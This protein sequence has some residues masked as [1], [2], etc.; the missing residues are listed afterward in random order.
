MSD[1]LVEIESGKSK[2][3]KTANKVCTDNI[4][5][6][7]V[8]GEKPLEYARMAPNFKG[9]ILPEGSEL[10]LDM[11]FYSGIYTVGEV[12]FSE[13]FYDATNLKK[14]ILKGNN[15]GLPLDAYCMFYR[16]Q[17]LEVVD[18][19]DFKFTPS[20]ADYL[21]QRSS[22]LVSING[23]IDA[24]NMVGKYVFGYNAALQDVEFVP[25]TISVSLDFSSSPNLSTESVDSI[26][27]GLADLTGGTAQTLTVYPNIKVMIEHD[28]ERLAKVTGKNWN[29]A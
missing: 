14:V 20:R 5:V 21:F 19:Q 27:D 25:N 7:G 24:T 23:K 11:P 22:N 28:P 13:A 12:G 15:S 26:I 6:S 16:T 2:R 17:Q 10:T 8:G 9:V 18:I 1:I 4:V 3:L 29:L